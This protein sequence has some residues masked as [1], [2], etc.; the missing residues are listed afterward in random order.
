VRVTKGH[1]NGASSPTI[2]LVHGSGH[3][4]RVWSQVQE[5]LAHGSVAVDVPGRADRVAPIAEVTLD[6]AATSLAADIDQTTVEPL[7]LVGHSAGG[8]VLPGLA[9]RLGDRVRHLVFVAGLCAP[10]GEAV[11]MTVRPEA[12]DEFERRLHALRDEFAGC[13]LDPD[14]SVE[15]M[16]AIDTTTAAGIDSLNLMSQ[17]VSW[18]GVPDDVPRTFVRCTRDRIQPPA[19]QAALAEHCGASRV[20]DLESGHTPALAVPSELAALLDRIADQHAIMAR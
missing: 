8:I 5:Q 14:P 10:D 17:T 15:A 11:V 1:G 6:A 9:A 19:L 20:I 13:M 2:V 4:A 3:T 18:A 7:V 12:V 16:C